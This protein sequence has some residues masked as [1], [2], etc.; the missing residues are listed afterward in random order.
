MYLL[1]S[2]VDY[3]HTHVYLYLRDYPGISRI[4]LG[5]CQDFSGIPRY[6]S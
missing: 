1:Y 4:H 5:K 2:I 3:I 6:I